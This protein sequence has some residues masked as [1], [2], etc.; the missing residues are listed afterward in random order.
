MSY[1]HAV[2]MVLICMSG[3]ALSGCLEEEIDARQSELVQGL[4]YKLHDKEPFSGRITGFP[5]RQMGLSIKI[6]T[7]NIEVDKGLPNGK[8]ECYFS[9]GQLGQQLTFTKGLID[10][11]WKEWTANGELVA[12]REFQQHKLH[13]KSEIYDASTGKL[14][15]ENHYLHGEYDGAQKV[16]SA[17]G[18]LITDL[19][20]SGG[21]KTGFETTYDKEYNWRDGEKHGV[22]RQYSTLKGERYLSTEE[23]YEDGLLHG[24]KRVFYSDGEL[25]FE[26]VY[27]QGV[28]Q[29]KTERQIQYGK[30]TLE[31]SFV[32]NPEKDS[33]KKSYD[34]LTLVPDGVERSWDLNGNLL[35]EIHWDHGKALSGLKQQWHEDKLIAVLTGV[36]NPEDR[37]FLLKHG[38]ERR[39]DGDGFLQSIIEW[40]RGKAVAFA[41][42]RNLPFPD[43]VLKLYLLRNA[44]FIY[45][46]FE[47]NTASLGDARSDYLYPI[48][49]PDLSAT[50]LSNAAKTDLNVAECVSRYQQYRRQTGDSEGANDTYTLTNRCS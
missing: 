36:P 43:G 13:G 25:A 23:V 22:Q 39:H 9:N 29:S 35:N 27:V 8:A 11:T 7:C 48:K 32:R 30:K 14:L 34:A 44:E 41:T 46:G 37:R 31:R 4:I 49:T 17:D 47:E 3:I 18:T 16:W 5:S 19:Q 10:G 6:P 12:S 38:L 50:T 45:G 20:M 21:K 15:R 2:K 24:T 1:L 33:S 40:D 26:E 28:I 42:G